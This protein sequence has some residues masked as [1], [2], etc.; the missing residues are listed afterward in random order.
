MTDHNSWS[1]LFITKAYAHDNCLGNEK[2]YA[3][4]KVIDSNQ[5][6]NI[7]FCFTAKQFTLNIF[8]FLLTNFVN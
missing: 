2:I 8:H 1:F 5:I 7:S 4:W 3:F 6:G